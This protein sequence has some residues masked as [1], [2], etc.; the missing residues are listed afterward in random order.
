MSTAT[1]NHFEIPLLLRRMPRSEVDARIDSAR[2]HLERERRIGFVMELLEAV[3]AD[4]GRE[5][6]A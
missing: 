6:A 3:R 1:L 2:A 4:D 5:A